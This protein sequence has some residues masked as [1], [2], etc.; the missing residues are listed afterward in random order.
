MRVMCLVVAAR[1]R[2]WPA[3]WKSFASTRFTILTALVYCESTR[4]VIADNIDC[5]SASANGSIDWDRREAHAIAKVFDGHS[6]EVPVSAIKSL[7]GET[8]GA[9]GALQVASAV[10]AMGD[11]VLPGISGLNQLEHDFPLTHTTNCNQTIDAHLA[12]V[13]S[14]GFDGQC[15]SLVI[16]R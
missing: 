6:G 4:K 9:A 11:G 15:C 8:L 13:N 16:A 2:C 1:K 14:I 5:I 3:A 10:Q 12:L 7:L